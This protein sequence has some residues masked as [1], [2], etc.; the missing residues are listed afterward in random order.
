ML[1]TIVIEL[2]DHKT[3]RRAPARGWM[4]NPNAIESLPHIEYKTHGN[5]TDQLV[6]STCMC[7]NCMQ[8]GVYTSLQ[9][10]VSSLKTC[11]KLERG[12]ESPGL[13]LCTSRTVCCCDKTLQQVVSGLPIVL[14]DR[15]VHRPAHPI[16]QLRRICDVTLDQP[17]LI[18]DSRPN[19]LETS[20]SLLQWF[21]T[22]TCGGLLSSVSCDYTP[23]GG[24]T[25]ASK[26][27]KINKSPTRDVG[28]Q[29][30]LI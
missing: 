15:H 5:A 12:M 28:Q 26:E 17:A 11:S 19:R 20:V 14:R 13:D 24:C 16:C 30:Y 7:A 29:F 3:V 18:Q 2:G 1:H 21:E 9:T 4:D 8:S 23:H 10:G 22:P 6:L 27:T 25:Q